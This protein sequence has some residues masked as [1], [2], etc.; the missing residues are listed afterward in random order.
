[1]MSGKDRSCEVIERAVTHGAEVTLSVGLCFVESVFDDLG[2]VA[3]RAF[4]TFR[5][6]KLANHRVALG[7][8]DQS[9]NVQSHRAGKEGLTI[10]GKL[11]HFKNYTRLRQDTQ[12]QPGTQVEP[13]NFS[14]RSHW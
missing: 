3:V 2:G 12:D 7:I 13:R 5:P 9:V 4:D 10:L 14:N 8:I 11:P 1:M 6:T